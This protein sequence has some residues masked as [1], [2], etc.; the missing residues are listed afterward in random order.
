MG[1]TS[2]RGPRAPDGQVYLCGACGR[3]GKELNY[4]GDESCVANAILCFEAKENGAWIAVSAVP[5]TPTPIVA[6]KVIGHNGENVAPSDPKGR[7]AGFNGITGAPIVISTVVSAEGRTVRTKSGSVY[8]LLDA[9]LAFQEWCAKNG[10]A[11][12]WE[13]P[14]GGVRS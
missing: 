2:D 6:W 1:A 5:A 11:V 7:V 4:V 3:F 8:E 13:R 10:V 12:D 14:F 9:Q